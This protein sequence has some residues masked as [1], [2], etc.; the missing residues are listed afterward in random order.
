MGGHL[1]PLRG[2]QVPEDHLTEVDGLAFY[3]GALWFVECKPDAKGLRERARL[4]ENLVRS[5]GGSWSKGLMVARAW[6]EPP[7]PKS[8]NLV[9]MA[10]EAGEG[11]LRFPQDLDK[12]L[13]REDPS[14]P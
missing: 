5:V 1:V 8:D 3:R 2:K 11:A 6:Q 4:M 10:W 7:P 14:R 13:K 9:F 12:A